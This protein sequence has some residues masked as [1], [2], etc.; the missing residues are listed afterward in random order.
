M[1]IRNS[2][3]QL[4]LRPCGVLEDAK[5]HN[6]HHNI[7]LEVCGKGSIDDT[8]GDH[9]VERRRQFHA[10]ERPTAAALGMKSM[11]KV[12][13]D[14]SVS[15][16]GMSLCLGAANVRHVDTQ[17][18]WVQGSFH[19]RDATIRKIPGNQQTS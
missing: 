17:W 19:K 12:A 8:D 1:E 16:R 6:K 2:T 10:I 9:V 7:S 18:L 5:V 3:F 4:T 11:A 14:D 15:G 13:F